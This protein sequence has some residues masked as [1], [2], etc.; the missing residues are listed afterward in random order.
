M[1]K[2]NPRPLPDHCCFCE[3]TLDRASLAISVVFLVFQLFNFV[4]ALDAIVAAVA[5]VSGVFAAVGVAGAWIGDWR[6]IDVFLVYF[7]LWNLYLAGTFIWFLVLGYPTLPMQERVISIF[8]LVA[9][10]P[11]CI[12]YARL[13][14]MAQKYM[15][16]GELG[17]VG[18]P[19]PEGTAGAQPTSTT[20]A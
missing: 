14:W 3:M 18:R 8:Y 20:T 9:I 4:F 2:K 19:L 1:D 13:L 6:L 10:F 17:G 15:R 7:T 11:L 12:Y 5:A 16:A